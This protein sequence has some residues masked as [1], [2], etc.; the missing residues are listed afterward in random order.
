MEKAKK[1]ELFFKS[2]D[3]ALLLNLLQN[4]NFLILGLNMAVSLQIWLFDAWKAVY[5]VHGFLFMAF[6]A[7]NLLGCFML[8]L[9]VLDC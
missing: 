6:H 7:F 5:C 1:V 2:A 3:N 8:Y 4:A 9:A